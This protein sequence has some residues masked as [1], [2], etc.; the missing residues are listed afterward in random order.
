M[1]RTVLAHRRTRL[2]GDHPDTLL[3]MFTLAKLEFDARRPDQ[4]IPLAREFLDRA[5]KIEGRLPAKVRD[6]IPATAGWLAEHYRRA[7]RD[8]LAEPFRTILQR[9]P[10]PQAAARGAPGNPLAPN[11]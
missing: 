1:F 2:G 8:D 4:A 5:G 11:Q 3:T 9:G 7:G 6:A 10:S